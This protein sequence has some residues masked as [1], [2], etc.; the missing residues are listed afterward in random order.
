MLSYYSVNDSFVL[1]TSGNIGIGTA[2][3]R[4]TIDIANRTDAII[5]PSQEVSTTEI[6]PENTPQTGRKVGVLRMNRAYGRFEKKMG[7]N[8]AVTDTWQP[9][10]VSANPTKLQNIGMQTIVDGLFFE[11]HS[12]WSF[13][14]NDGTHFPCISQFVNQSRVILTRPNV[15]PASKS[16]FRLRVYNTE[17]AREFISSTI[18]IDAGVGPTFTTPAGSLSNLI[19]N[20]LY[21][22]AMV[23][24]AIDE[25]GGGITNIS[26]DSDLSGSGLSASFSNS[27]LTIAGTTVNSETL[28]TFNTIATAQDSGGNTSSRAY[29]FTIGEPKFV[30]TTGDVLSGGY[31]HGSELPSIINNYYMRSCFTWSYSSDELFAAF[32]YKEKANIV[33]MQFF[34]Q[35]QPTYQPYPSYAIGMKLH[36][37]SISSNISGSNGGQM[38]R[39]KDPSSETF[40]TGVNKVFTFTTPMLWTYGFNLGIS[41]AWGQTT[42]WSTSGTM[43]VASGTSFYQ[44][45]D[46]AGTYS[47]DSPVGNSVTWRPVVRFIC[48]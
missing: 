17:A 18:L 26:I 10:I 7:A 9:V 19:P 23:I 27:S 29:S 40:V 31:I 12:T 22:P 3:P 34:V 25:I 39:V 30:G 11:L 35:T 43:F 36:N 15:F 13:I 8:W 28:L 20:T 45:Q 5:I 37:M 44:W 2:F 41:C 42:N 47:F 38:I 1:D 14:G 4:S 21:N 6:E 46:G 16:P 48:A 33:G 32:N 24:N